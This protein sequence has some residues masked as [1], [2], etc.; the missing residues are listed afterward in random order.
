MVVFVEI[1]RRR[2][3]HRLSHEMYLGMTVET[4]SYILQEARV[5]GD[6]GRHGIGLSV[7][8]WTTTNAI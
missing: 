3:G 4:T 7:A 2:H 6:K 5:L 8:S 1:N